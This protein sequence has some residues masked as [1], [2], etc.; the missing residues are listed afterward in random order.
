W[1]AST[2]RR[3][4][5]RGTIDDLFDEVIK[6][7]Q[8]IAKNAGFDNARDYM[9]KALKRFDYTPADCDAFAT[10]I[11]KHVVPLLRELDD[12]RRQ[13]RGVDHLR[14]WDL[15]VDP[16]GRDPLRPFGPDDID[17]LVETTRTVFEKLDPAL[18]ADFAS[19][20][21]AGNLDLDSRKGKQPGGYQCNLEETG[22]PFIFMN[23]AGL[24]R[25][26]ETLLHEGGHPFHTLAAADEPLTFLRHAPMEFCE[27][28]S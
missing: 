1:I 14:P 7:R 4:A 17:A 23:A 27:V 8:Q 28:A 3:L 6:L 24:Q 10:A 15:A 18:A 20:R 25:D 26:V 19:L 16:K 21:S 11:E 5:D 22:I 2:N 13:A 9:F 12:E